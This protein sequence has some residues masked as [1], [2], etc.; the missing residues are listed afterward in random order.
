[1][2]TRSN[3]QSPEGT[4]LKCST[5]YNY[6]RKHRLL[7]QLLIFCAEKEDLEPWL[8]L[9]AR[10]I[11]LSRSTD[12]PPSPPRR[13]Q[14]PASSFITSSGPRA[15]SSGH[16]RAPRLVEKPLSSAVQSQLV[17]HCQE[18]A[19]SRRSLPI[20]VDRRLP[21]TCKDTIFPPDT[22]KSNCTFYT[23]S[24]MTRIWSDPSFSPKG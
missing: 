2:H 17:K 4:W 16:R 20:N 21:W 8:W 18:A 5:S 12:L 13:C 1:M 23:A 9:Q 15:A 22:G 6:K 14:P 19:Q 24:V 7:F 10:W 3:E 11:R